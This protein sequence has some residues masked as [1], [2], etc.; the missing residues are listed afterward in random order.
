[1]V[2]RDKTKQARWA[3]EVLGHWSGAWSYDD[4]IKAIRIFRDCNTLSYNLSKPSIC[5]AFEWLIDQTIMKEE[6][7]E[8]I[9]R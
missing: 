4:R 8:K 3:R 2:I 1:M 6:N 7:D 5:S 9:F